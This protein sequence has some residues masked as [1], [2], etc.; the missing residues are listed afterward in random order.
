M[1]V[2]WTKV[3]FDIWHNK[4]RTLLAVVSIAS[5]VFAIGAM[6]GLADLL[7]KGMDGAHQAVTPS[8][9]QM[10]TDRPV[11]RDTLL[12]LRKVPG[13]EGV[14]P[15]N[16][17]TVRYKVGPDAEWKMGILVMRDDY[18]HMTYDVVQLKEGNWPKRDGIAIERLSAQF[19]NLKLGDEIIF[20]IDKQEKS[21][22]VVGKIRHPFVPPPQFGGQ[23]VFFVDS[24]GMERFGIQKGEFSHFF[25]RVTPYSQPF[26]KEVAS[27]IKNRLGKQGINIAATLYQDPQKHWGRF[28]MEGMITVLQ[29]LAVVSLF[30]SVILV[31]NTLMALITQQTNQIGVLKAIGGRTTTV[32]KV[33]LAGVLV[34]GLL[35]LLISL[36]LGM[37]LA[38]AITRAFLNLFN[39]DYEAFA[40]SNTAVALQVGAAIVAPLV[41]ALLP[42]LKGATITVREAIA[43][44]GLGGDFGAGRLD[45]AVE[46]IGARLLPP[47]Y[48]MALA[49]TIRRKGRLM[50]SLLVLV[51]AGTMFLIVM[52]LSA[53]VTATLDT[54]FA[55]RTYDISLTFQRPERIDSA[56]DFARAQDGVTDATMWAGQ[57][58]TILLNGQKA[59]EA[60]LGTDLLGL[61][62]AGA[63]YRPPVV[64]GRW[65]QPGDT[66]AAVISKEI[67]DDNRIRLGDMIT[68]DLGQAGKTDWQVVGMY[69][70]IF[71]GGFRVDAIYAPRDEVLYA[72]RKNPRATSLYLRSNTGSEAEAGALSKGLEQAF[73]AANMPV[74][75]SS[76]KYAD[77]KAANGGFAIVIIMLLALAVIVAVVGGLGL[78]GSLWISVI[79]RTKELGVLRA[80]GGRS[81]TIRGMLILEGVLQCLVSW[82]IAVPLSFL[83]GRQLAESMGQAMFSSSLTY[84]YDYPAV[85]IWLALVLA[86][87][88]LAALVPARKATHISVR[89]SLA[90]E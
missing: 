52:T 9:I 54:E 1:S 87:A 20:E 33:Y 85:G 24:A 39:I 29:V 72:A 37:L 89:E 36:P 63:M 25:V 28:F 49:N 40:W 77:R 15:N 75:S 76:T 12:A 67:A 62:L 16:E 60:G 4:M 13:V 58:V 2:L 44:Y 11:D 59:R 46:R 78:T 41:A 64:A 71:G 84:R 45:R 42:V 61:P 8:H 82:A 23:A 30:M 53:S 70:V 10:Y 26:A 18:S 65:L 69:Q 43:S 74:L 73:K 19:F 47:A 5:G 6:F 56:V 48:A 88:V 57:P 50:L 14:E 3:W 55:R 86:I 81:R 34:L 38:Y 31:F 80:I 83:L 90:Y 35:A 22:P 7:Y 32:V 68:L 51:T 27:R 21:L 79:E 66:R 17:I